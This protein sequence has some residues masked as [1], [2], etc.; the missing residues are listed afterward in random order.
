VSRTTKRRTNQSRTN[1]RR[2]DPVA[3][4]QARSRSLKRLGR[5]VMLGMMMAVTG[6]GAVWLNR[7]W[8]VTQWDIK[9]EAPIRA[10]I[11]AQLQ[12]MPT[13]DFL[14]TRPELLRRQWLQRIPDLAAVQITRILPH[15]LAIQAVARVP[16]ALWQDEQGQ[17]HLFDAQG[18][19][20][21]LLRKGESPDLPLLRIPASQLS[22]ARSMLVALAQHDA[23]QLS[24][25]S[26]IRGGGSY[27]QVYFNR[28]ETWLMP[29][30]H[31]AAVIHHI[32]ALLKR[33]RWSGRHWRVD[34]RLASRWFLRPAGHGGVI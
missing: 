9:A 19:A 30:G 23:A 12:S 2:I 10:A 31:E 24:A 17:L 11:A 5:I 21:R 13:R 1:Q 14:S 3:Q 4:K 8:S 34:A 28:G 20:Y 22:S 16:A 29:V 32:T 26:E 33:P 6:S 25:L 27:W 15:R 7:Q 18:H